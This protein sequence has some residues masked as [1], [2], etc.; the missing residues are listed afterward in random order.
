MDEHELSKEHMDSMKALADTNMKI[1][2]AKGTL[3]KLQEQETSYL[4][5]REEKVHARIQKILDDSKELLAEA[6]ANYSKIKELHDTVSS[7]SSF[8]SSAYDFFIGIL[9]D[10]REK[11]DLW[12][13]QASEI[14]EGFAKIRQEINNDRIR[15]KND[16]E[17]LIQRKK[18]LDVEKV[19][20][21]SDRGEL[22]RAITRLK[23]N[24]I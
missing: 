17:A 16:Q 5:E 4:K 6:Q 3:L 1:G 2:E 9:K 11:N 18:V 15:I 22:D 10:F 21:D 19:K 23:E 13:N 14:E 8:L 12:D 7:F 24:R 20:I